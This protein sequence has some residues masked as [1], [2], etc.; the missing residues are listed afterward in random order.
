MPHSTAPRI[1]HPTQWV[2]NRKMSQLLWACCA[3]L[4]LGATGKLYAA[5]VPDDVNQQVA[6][7]QA[8]E[9]IV[10]Y[11]ST[12][13]DRDLA[14]QRA[15]L[16]RGVSD[17][18]LLALTQTRYQQL[19]LA[20][21]RAITTPDTD[22]ITEYSHLPMRTVRVRSAQG[23]AALAANPLIR[24]IYANGTV[25]RTQSLDLTQIGQPTVAAVGYGG[26]GTTVAVIDDGIEVTN[27][28]FGC[29][30][31]GT[32]STCSIAAYTT[33]VSN[34]G[35]DFSHGTN[36][37]AIVTSVAPQAKVAMLNVFSAT[38]AKNSDVIKGI[39]WAIAN[40]STYNI[41][42]VSMSLGDGSY[43]TSTCSSGN[44]FVTPV[45]N[46]RAA[47]ITVVAAA[48][49]SAYLNG[50][51]VPGISSPACTPGV[52]SVGA[53]YDGNVGGLIW[54]T[55]PNQC[56]D[57]TSQADQIV[58][59]SQSAPILTMLAPGAIITAAGISDGG[60]SQA[61]PHVSGAVAVLRAAFPADTL[62]TTQTRLT[63]SSVNITDTR[64]G[65]GDLTTPRLSMPDAARPTNDN[66][67][68]RLSASGSSGSTTG[69]NLLAT[70]EAGE[71]QP[72]TPGT[73]S[74]WWTW[75]APASGQ[76]SLSS[77]GSNF[78][79][80]VS[81]YTG[82]SL[83]TLTPIASTA[84]AA[85]SSAPLLF[86]AQS[87]VTYQWAVE[88]AGSASGNINLQWALNTAA[89]ADLSSNISGP[90]SVTAGSTQ[91]Y[92]VTVANAGPQT[93]TGV[94]VTVTLP[95]GTT[96]ASTPTGC[97]ANGA[98]LSC[99]AGSLA[100]GATASWTLQLSITN[101]GT[102]VSLTASVS[103]DLPDPS[104]SNNST[105][106]AL[107]AA[108]VDNGEVPLPPWALALMAIGL[109]VTGARASRQSKL[110]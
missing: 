44:S 21:D 9:V 61:T 23:L 3:V 43:N 106:L 36:V 50:A 73:S 13:V 55:S 39:N 94:N 82:N 83:S 101:P 84:G 4:L 80:L 53:V 19:K 81:V 48:G 63:T 92:V 34:P 108:A 6:D 56:T 90:T 15:R 66:F 51:F 11:D 47:G 32:P 17:K 91:A 35:T 98:T 25:R 59:F 22:T 62:A 105:T 100:N 8:V 38:Q 79:N 76:L 96:L 1:S 31:V 109:V 72:A 86:E 60:T 37:S 42:A 89:A 18:A 40:R 67:A 14:R 71:P 77:A 7:G 70:L 102:G 88:S 85:Q 46:A 87:G 95:T 110:R 27:P 5:S 30:A 2:C 57:Y 104:S 12:Q 16:A 103:S 54:G 65:A 64:S 107:Q 24:A 52:I 69:V 74:V 68:A 78:T 29:T 49:N 75:T 97:V 93:A 10:E 99:A 33:I 28:A 58:C 41:V 20:A 45:S 26:A